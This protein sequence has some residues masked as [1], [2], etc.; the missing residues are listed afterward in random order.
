MFI[1]ELE[2]IQLGFE[3]IMNMTRDTNQNNAQ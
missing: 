3:A 1:K 2:N